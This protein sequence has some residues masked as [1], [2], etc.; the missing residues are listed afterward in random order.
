MAFRDDRSDDDEIP[1]DDVTHLV[2][3]SFVTTVPTNHSFNGKPCVLW[4]FHKALNSWS[5]RNV[6]FADVVS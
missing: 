5:W 1:P 4:I 6:L 3:D 2:V